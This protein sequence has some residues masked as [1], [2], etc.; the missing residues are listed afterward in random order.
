MAGFRC[1]EHSQTMKKAW[2]ISLILTFLTVACGEPV[3][4]WQ[5]LIDAGNAEQAI[6]VIDKRVKEKPASVEARVY[7]AQAYRVASKPKAAL[8]HLKYARNLPMEGAIQSLF[9]KEIA[10][11]H[12][13]IGKLLNDDEKYAEAEDHLNKALDTATE[14]REIK[15]QL[16]KAY[17]G[18]EKLDKAETAL[19]EAVAGKSDDTESYMALHL[20]FASQEDK[21]KEAEAVL[22]E[23][24]LK[25]PKHMPFFVKLGAMLLAQNPKD[26]EPARKAF[27]DGITTFPQDEYF[28]TK[29]I[30]TLKGKKHKKDR[31]EVYQL[32]VKNQP[33]NQQ[34]C[35]NALEHMTDLK[36]KGAEK[37]A[38][39]DRCIESIE[40]SYTIYRL[41]LEY[42][43]EAKKAEWAKLPKKKRPRK[44]DQKQQLAQEKMGYVDAQLILYPK[45]TVL[46]A[47]KAKLIG[48][49]E[50]SKAALAF[51]DDALTK[52]GGN[53]DLLVVKAALLDSMKKR[54]EAIDV[55][56]KNEKAKTY[57]ANEFYREELAYL[58]LK[59]KKHEELD[60]FAEGLKGI[61]KE[62]EWQVFSEKVAFN[63]NAR[64]CAAMGK[65]KQTGELDYYNSNSAQ[66]AEHYYGKSIDSG[67]VRNRCKHLPISIGIVVKMKIKHVVKLWIVANT[68][69]TTKKRTFYFN[70][71]QPGQTRYFK[72]SADFSVLQS[73]SGL[74]G[75][76]SS[77]ESIKA[78]PFLRT[79]K[80]KSFEL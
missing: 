5:A 15:A 30:D 63:K 13:E 11:T 75:M 69:Y 1:S 40:D 8:P 23:A 60:A 10:L 36:K 34:A 62:S 55:L 77:L 50:N 3:Q 42:L 28:Y 61:I 43:V 74:L 19:K 65:G 59:A 52:S 33:K 76:G 9:L 35:L 66:T 2:L 21:G 45:R 24:I 12:C 70:D 25:N 57:F 16:G 14:V 73:G 67:W 53:S 17:L 47:V 46:F 51:L 26:K 7:L 79:P 32:Q 64:F 41:R 78:Y 49:K 37:L 31:L 29:L 68:K 58:L 54:D 22:R 71:I 48:E 56:Q 18:Q 27:L 39:A 6:S 44:K 80:L 38:F 20:T 72:S 4:E